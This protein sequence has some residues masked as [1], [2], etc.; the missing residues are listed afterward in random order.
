MNKETQLLETLADWNFWH[1]SLPDTVPRERYETEVLSKSTTGEIVIVKGVRRSGKSTILVNALRRLVDSGVSPRE[2]MFVN[3]EDPRFIG[4]LEPGL[5]SRIKDTYLQH[6]NPTGTPYLILDE[7]Q[8]VPGFEKWLLREYELGNARLLVTGSNAKL[9]SREIGTALTGRYLDV[10]VLPLAFDEFLSFKGVNPTDR[11]ELAQRRLDIK[12]LFEEYVDYGGF[13]KVALTP[14]P[15][16]KQAEVRI[17]FDSIVLRDIVARYRLDNFEAL[18]QLAV[19]ILSHASSPLSLN[20]LK[21]HF[22]LSFDLVDRY[23]E[24]LENAY[25]I[26]RVPRFDWSL[27]RQHANPRKVYAVDTGLS[28]AVSFQ[29][30]DRLGQR[31][32]NLVFLELVRRGAEVYYYKTQGGYEVDFVVKRGPHIT[33]LIQVCNGM[34]HKKT[35]ERELRAL[36]KATQEIAHADRADH[37]V[38]VPDGE[39]TVVREGIEIRIVDVKSWLLGLS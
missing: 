32:E 7:I 18:L 24:Y 35:R 1:R 36:V 17:Y 26:F 20:G 6:L 28:N 5:L 39:E 13:P 14:E 10:N 4:Q 8:N 15:V 38:L 16:L 2:M 22:G 19:Y 9:S 27:K 3:L 29:V 25:L 11:L 37:I 12:R 23:V 30:G 31:L 33:Q 21:T 34:E